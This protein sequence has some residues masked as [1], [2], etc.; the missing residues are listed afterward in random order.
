MKMVYA[1]SDEDR[2]VIVEGLLAL[3][4][5]AAGMD[6]GYVQT[7]SRRLIALVRKLQRLP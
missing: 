6:M 5:V 7:M 1:I 3:E 4:R 2:K